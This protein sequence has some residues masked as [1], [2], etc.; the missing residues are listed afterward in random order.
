LIALI[1][2]RI[3]PSFRLSGTK[4]CGATEASPIDLAAGGSGEF[5]GKC[6]AVG[7][8]QMLVESVFLAVFMVS[9]FFIPTFT[10]SIS[11]ILAIASS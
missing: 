7:L 1:S 2:S 11:R 8:L 3:S 9:L 5:Y 10:A 4:F 6:S